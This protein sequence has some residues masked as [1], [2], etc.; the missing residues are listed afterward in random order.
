MKNKQE[1]GHNNDI[2]EACVGITY[3]D[4]DGDSGVCIEVGNEGTWAKLRWVSRPNKTGWM[5][6]SFLKEARIQR[7]FCY[8][9]DRL[10][11][12]GSNSIYSCPLGF[13]CHKEGYININ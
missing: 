13:G 6:M 7:R 4:R 2:Q 5:P 12:I 9:C 8:I 3:V 10:L 1:S 11:P